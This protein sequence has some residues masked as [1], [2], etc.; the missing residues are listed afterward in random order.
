[1]LPTY[2]VTCL[3]K[4]RVRFPGV[5]FHFLT[6]Q[7][8]Q[9]GRI[10]LNSSV[11]SSLESASAYY[12]DGRSGGFQLRLDDIPGGARQFYCI[13]IQF[14]V[15]GRIKA[16]QIDFFAGSEQQR[17]STYLPASEDEDYPTFV[18][19]T[20]TATSNGA[21]AVSFYSDGNFR[22]P[23]DTLN[24]SGTTLKWIGFKLSIGY[25]YGM[26]VFVDNIRVYADQCPN[27]LRVRY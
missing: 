4:A 12:G 15:P 2:W 5:H 10:V 7:C 22:N 24:L 11:P 19:A 25:P 9:G 17:V 14:Q 8:L 1:M 21:Y 3:H 27:I 16:S 13:D 6:I 18:R 23:I 20:A 26:S